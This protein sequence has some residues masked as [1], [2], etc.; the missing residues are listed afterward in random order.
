MK[1]WLCL[2]WGAFEF[3][4]GP[5]ANLEKITWGSKGVESGFGM[6]AGGG[7]AMTPCE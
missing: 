3:N 5:V 6:V 2:V 4:S 1:A 7:V